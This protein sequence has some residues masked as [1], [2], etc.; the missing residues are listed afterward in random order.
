MALGSSV[1]HHI[2]KRCCSQNGTYIN[3]ANTR[4]RKGEKYELKSGD[5]LFLINPRKIGSDSEFHF[6]FVNKRERDITQRAVLAAHSSS[7]GS[8]R[9]DDSY[10][11]S[12]SDSTLGEFDVSVLL[13]WLIDE[14]SGYR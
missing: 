7:E 13:G 9:T 3:D 10:R 2:H 8:E 14:A 4:L 12:V 11:S 6:I 5:E 1:L